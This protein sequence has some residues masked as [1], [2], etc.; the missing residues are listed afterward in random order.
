MVCPRSI[1]AITLSALLLPVVGRAQSF[2]EPVEVESTASYLDAQTSAI[3][4]HKNA[5]LARLAASDH[6]HWA[7]PEAAEP[8][9]EEFFRRRLADDAILRDLFRRST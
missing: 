5:L 3:D 8:S 9:V 7:W 4:S 6:A 1:A 2:C